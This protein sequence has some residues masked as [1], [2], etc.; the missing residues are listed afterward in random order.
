MIAVLVFATAL[1]ALLGFLYTAENRKR[2]AAVQTLG[3]VEDRSFLDLT[4]RR[5]ETFQVSQ[6]F[7]PVLLST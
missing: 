1:T 7:A 4:D 6:G 3:V 5:D 2:V